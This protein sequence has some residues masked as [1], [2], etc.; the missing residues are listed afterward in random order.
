MSHLMKDFVL[1]N[2]VFIGVILA[3]FILL[4]GGVFLFSRNDPSGDSK[5]IADTIL[6]PKDSYKFT[7]ASTPLT[8]V[9]FGDYQCPACGAYHPLVQKLLEDFSG[10]L[11]FVFRHFPLSQHANAPISSY[12]VEASGLQGKFW[13][14]HDKIYETQGAWSGSA[15]ARSIFVGYAKDLGL[16]VEKFKIDIDSKAVKDKISRDMA[17]GN[18]INIDSTPT[19]FLNGEKIKLAGNY[20]E[21]KKMVQDALD[22]K[23][24]V[25]GADASPYH[26]HFDLKVYVAGNA[27]NLSLP[28]YQSEEGKELDP[29]VHIHDRQGKVAHIHKEGTT[30]KQFFDSLKVTIPADTI[31]YVNSKKVENI[32]SYVPQ[33]LDRIL[34]GGSKT[35]EV[36]DEACIYSLKCPERGTPPP[37]ACVGDLG[38]D[39]EE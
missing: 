36:T 19:F 11:N 37:E 35:G 21:L 1:R 6:V 30:L 15:D 32:L 24:Q 12:A 9:E 34:I 7:N 25:E 38:T 8:L 31:A 10:K 39:C 18:L 13:E 4:F 2:K 3:T 27:L 14:M 22:K 26:I 28:E 29:D 16:N 17:D 33:D 5:K 20:E 23:P